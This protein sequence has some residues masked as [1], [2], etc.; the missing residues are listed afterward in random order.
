MTRYILSAALLTPLAA[1][2]PTPGPEVGLANPAATFC[3]EKGG[4]YDIVDGAEGQ[5]GTCTLP[6]GSKQDAWE[7]FRAENMG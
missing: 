6:D 2:D 4:T 1:C 3:V 5:T 7:F